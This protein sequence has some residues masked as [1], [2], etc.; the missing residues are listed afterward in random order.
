MIVRQHDSSLLLITQ[1]DHA[2]LAA[3]VMQHWV[4]NGLPDHPHRSSILH[5]IAEHDNG[6]QEVD[7]AP[8]VDAAGRIA[9]FV[10]RAG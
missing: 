5:A 7:A 3:R 4:A 1:P 9:D 8:L 6:W 10:E 2:A